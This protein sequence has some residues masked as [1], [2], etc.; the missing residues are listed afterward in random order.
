MW[1]PWL[2]PLRPDGHKNVDNMDRQIINPWTWQ[3]HFGFVQVNAV[4]DVQR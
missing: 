3:D 2:G 4:T 1:S